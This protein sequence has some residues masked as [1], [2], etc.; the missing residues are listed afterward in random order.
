MEAEMQEPEIVETKSPEATMANINNQTG[1]IT[2]LQP[3]VQSQDQ[4]LKY[5]EQVSG[6]LATLPEYLGNFFNRYK[7]PLVSIGL[8]VAAIVAVKVVLAILDA[9]ND[10]PLVSPTFELIGIGYSTWFIYR[11]LLKASTR[12]EL[13]DEITTLK[14]QVVG[15]QIPES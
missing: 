5:G 4:W 6:F 8:I 13:T 10:I 9:L 11:Y 14:S 7:Q 2:K 1:S 12:Q 15:K 3:T